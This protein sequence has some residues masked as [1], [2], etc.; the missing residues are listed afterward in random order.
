[1]KVKTVVGTGS[2]ISY[3]WYSFVTVDR[4]ENV[5]TYSVVRPMLIVV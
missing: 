3:E 4:G 1:M 5:F 2:E